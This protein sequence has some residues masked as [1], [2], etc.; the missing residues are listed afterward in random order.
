M[1]ICVVCFV[2]R[3]RDLRANGNRST[4]RRA[5]IFQRS[6]WWSTNTEWS[7]L[8]LN[9]IYAVCVCYVWPLCQCPA[10]HSRRCNSTSMSRIFYALFLLFTVFIVCRF[11]FSLFI[12][13][14]SRN[15]NYFAQQR[16]HIYGGAM[17]NDWTI[18]L[19][20]FSFFFRR[21]FVIFE[22]ASR[23]QFH[24]IATAQFF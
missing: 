8:N 5:G 20:I 7:T 24:I 6:V 3:R 21:L 23:P 9:G 2:F 10:T 17:S 4:D 22:C 1:L 16:L 13:M 18:A 15:G 14:C 19:E 12:L 11:V